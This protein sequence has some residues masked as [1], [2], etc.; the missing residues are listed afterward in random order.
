MADTDNL[1]RRSLRALLR[2][3]AAL[4][5][6]VFVPAWSLAYWQGWLFFA[7]FVVA[8]L[9]LSLYFLKHDPALVERR[10]KAGP[11]AEPHASQR[12]IQTLTS[13]AVCATV[14]VSALDHGRGWSSVPWPVVL[15]GD[16][17]I[18]YGFAIIFV[19]FREN[20]YAAGIVDVMAGQRVIATGPY[21]MVRHPMYSGAMLM[22]AGVPVA[23]GS[24]WGLLPAAIL[25][26]AIVWRLLDEEKILER[27]LPG[28]ADYRRAVRWRLMPGTW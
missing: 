11:T 22:F 7:V 25:A 21:A 4:F 8:T 1:A 6:F 12:R 18:L 16:A 15:L 24:Y 23:L 13:V 2:F 20:S 9:V 17:L 10:M 28:Y 26:G 14:I 27:E 19:V 5:V 3:F